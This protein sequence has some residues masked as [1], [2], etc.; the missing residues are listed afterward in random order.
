MTETPERCVE[1]AREFPDAEVLGLDIVPNKLDSVPSN[2]SF[3]T[4]DLN[5][6]LSQHHGRF[7]I[8]HARFIGH[9][10]SYSIS[11]TFYS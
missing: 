5:D 2:C 9:G 6:G 1:M 3:A 11:I 8:V 10:V 4:W 7:N